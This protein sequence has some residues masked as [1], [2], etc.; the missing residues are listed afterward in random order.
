MKEDQVCTREGFYGIRSM[1][2]SCIEEGDINGS[3][4]NLA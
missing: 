2:R 1:N 3:R 4:I